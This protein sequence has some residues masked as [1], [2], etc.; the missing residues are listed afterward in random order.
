MDVIPLDAVPNQTVSL[1]LDYQNCQINVYQKSTGLFVDLYKDNSLV[2]AGVLARNL[3]LIL[4][5]T[6]LGFSGDL[7]FYDNQGDHD[8][9]YAELG[10]RYSLLY[11]PASEMPAN[12]AYVR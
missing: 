5:G 7:M 9:E 2:I 6:Y 3:R 12:A 4:M 8:P 1:V 10:G 11:I